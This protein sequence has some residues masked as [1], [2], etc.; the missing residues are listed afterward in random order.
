MAKVGGYKI[1]EIYQGS[2]SSL[3]PEKSYSDNF[4]G[5]HATGGSLGTTTDPRTANIIK[6]ASAKLSSGI[7]HIELALVSPEIFDSIPKQ[8]FKEMGQMGKLLGTEVSV[9]GPVIDTAGITQQGFSELNRESSERKIIEVISRSREINPDGNIPVVFHSAEGI[10]GSEW[11]EIPD[12]ERGNFG[13]AKQL[14]AINRESGQM[15]P[16]KEERKFYPGKETKLKL[17][18]E[19]KL[20]RGEITEEEIMQNKEKYFE[21]IPFEQG[22]VYSPERNLGVANRSEWDNKISQLFFNKERADEILNN[23]AVQIQH[24]MNYINEAKRRNQEADLTPSQE[25]AYS[26]FQDAQNYLSEIN[27][28]ANSLFSK[29]YEY[30]DEFQ[31]KKLNEINEQYKKDLEKN[32]KDAVGQ[33]RAM[34]KLLSSLQDSSMAPEM[35]VPIEKFAVDQASKTFGNAAFNSYKKFKDKTPLICIENPPSGFALSTGEDL[36]NLVIASRKK[37]VE[38]A[39][40]EGISE[41]QAEE[42]AEKL[43]GATWDVGHINMLR[44]QGFDEKAI[45]KETEKIAPFVKHVHLSDNFGMEH[46]ELPMGMGN[47]P[48]KEIMEKLGQKGFEAKKIIEAGQWWQHFQTN[49]FKE[50]MEGLGSPMYSTGASPYWNQAIGLQQGYLGGYGQMLPDINYQTFGAGF[51]QLPTDLGGQRQGGSGSRMSGHGME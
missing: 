36:K 15:V 23:N 38:R 10:P 16:L 25:Q 28:T 8:H 42:Q 7:K 35:F 48:M 14:I 29:A 5:Y 47:V 41:K 9:H 12:L 19:E 43:I 18:V 45:I 13:K 24:L 31:R 1:N 30:G 26:K 50:T 32:G 4:T 34:H 17:D 3:D 40:Q 46:T 6:D 51:S 2:Y 49:P 22:R 39:V 20:H 33:S 27:T 37:F 11:K 21:K 44:K